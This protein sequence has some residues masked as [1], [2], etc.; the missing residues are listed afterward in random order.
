MR[1]QYF[2]DQ[3]VTIN[4]GLSFFSISVSLNV[5]V[6]LMIVFRLVLH[7]RNIRSAL[8]ARAGSGGVYNAIVTVLVESCALYAVSFLLFIGPWS[9]AHS[10]QYVFFPILIEIQVRATLCFPDV[11][12]PRNVVSDGDKQV[13]APFLIVLRVANKRALTS[14]TVVSGN[15][16]S[17]HFKSQERSAMTGSETVSGGVPVSSLDASG[18]TT[19]EYSDR[20]ETAIDEVSRPER[21]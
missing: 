13:I 17:M 21:S 10:V 12:Q 5:I 18:E 11:L 6:T 16:G 7:S 8:G 15:I 19:V 2:N 20:D 14:E 9:A 3:S 1:P 4:L